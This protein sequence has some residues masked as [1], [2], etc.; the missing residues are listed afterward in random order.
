MY[1]LRCVIPRSGDDEASLIVSPPV[2]IES[3]GH[4]LQAGSGAHAE[5]SNVPTVDRVA[6]AR[7]IGYARLASPGPHVF[8]GTYLGN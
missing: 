8:L 4:V 3:R 5:I 2:Y 6:P 1:G 7:E